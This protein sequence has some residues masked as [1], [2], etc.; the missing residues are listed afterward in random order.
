MG[1][2]TECRRAARRRPRTIGAVEPPE[3]IR[4]RTGV[5]E[6]AVARNPLRVGRTDDLA[7]PTETRTEIGIGIGRGNIPGEIDQDL[8][9]EEDRVPETEDGAAVV[10]EVEIGTEAE[11]AVGTTEHRRTSRTPLKIIQRP[12][13][14]NQSFLRNRMLSKTMVASWRCLKRCRNRCNRHKN[15]RL[16]FWRRK[17]W[18]PHL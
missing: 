13:Y 3:T 18:F 7:R 9:Q 16:L 12:S 17:L 8:D 10:T 6:G 2:K 15:R 1:T 14:N 11:K 4:H 5:G